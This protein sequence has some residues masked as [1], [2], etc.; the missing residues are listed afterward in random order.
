MLR[1][2]KLRRNRRKF[3]ALTGLTP[4]EFK[5][6]LSAF[7]RAYA[8]AYPANK[9]LIGTRRKRKAGG[10]RKGAVEGVEQ[11]LLFVLV[12]QKAYPLQ[13]LLG[14]VFDLS[15]SHANRW[16]HRLVPILKEALDD[17]GVLPERDPRQFARHEKRK[18]ETLGFIIDGTERRRQ[19]P[20]N[21]E[22]QAL[23][24][25]GKKKTHSDKNVLIVT[26]KTKRVGY[27]SPTYAGKTH[28]KKIAD[29]EPIVY[30]RGAVL[31][32]DTGFQG[33]EPLGCQ[34]YQPKKS[35]AGAN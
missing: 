18:Q 32:K 21:P 26:T 34:T 30:P 28:D 7:E 16:I 17:L 8:R 5:L 12:Y 33:Y 35:R 14:E 23:H 10:G 29:C 25:S 19:R 22:K 27:L 3:L 2:D 31:H 1:Y 4:K 13:E 6:L 20:K 9:T 24:Y 11:R 15:Q